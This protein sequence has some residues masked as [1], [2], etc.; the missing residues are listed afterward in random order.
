M[1]RFIVLLLIVITLP[2][3]AQKY[4]AGVYAGPNFSFLS[5]NSD[6]SFSWSDRYKPGFGFE[7][8]GFGSLKLS[9]KLS[10]D[11]SL[12]FQ[13]ITHRDKKT[14]HFT[15]E[16]GNTIAN[17]DLN[18][19]NN[20]YVTLSP[21]LSFKIIKSM[22]FG[23]GVNVNFLVFSKSNFKEIENVSRLKNT[24]YKFLNFSIPLVAGYDIRDFFIRLKFD[25]GLSNLMKDPDSYFVEKERTLS[26]S[27]GYFLFN[28]SSASTD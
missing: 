18:V 11:H 5:V 20:G 24:F 8:G 26:L 3:L 15:D 10:F 17:S 28:G 7:A 2:A 27:L 1:K 4:Q 25:F 13:F 6:F 23:T 9:G 19:I 16:V 21:Q 14:I 22:Y 12:S